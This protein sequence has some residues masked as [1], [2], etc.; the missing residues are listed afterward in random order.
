MQSEHNL[1]SLYLVGFVNSIMYVSISGASDTENCQ[2]KFFL[3]YILMQ[4]GFIYIP[5][6]FIHSFGHKTKNKC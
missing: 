1:C 3:F 5:L 6:Q 2:L 4:S